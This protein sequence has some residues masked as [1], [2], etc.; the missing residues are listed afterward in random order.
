MLYESQEYFGEGKGRLFEFFSNIIVVIRHKSY[1]KGRQ[2]P[3][4]P[5]P[6]IQDTQVLTSHTNQTK[7]QLI[8]F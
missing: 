8:W 3:L 2:P 6:W 1:P 5:D 4:R 7:S